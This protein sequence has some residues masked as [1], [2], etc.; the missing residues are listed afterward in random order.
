MNL[1]ISVDFTGSNGDP[2]YQNSLHYISP[3]QSICNDY[4][5][6]LW[7]VSKILLQWDSDKIVPILGFGA[8]INGQSSVN[9]CFEMF[10][11][12]GV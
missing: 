1:I 2:K 10:Q 8:R 7:S 9:H 11:G 3:N 4:Q 12:Q 5:E 6:C